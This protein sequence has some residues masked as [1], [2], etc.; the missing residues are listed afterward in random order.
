MIPLSKVGDRKSSTL[1]EPALLEV[2]TRFVT[3]KD[4]ALGRTTASKHDLVVV[5]VVG[6]SLAQRQKQNGI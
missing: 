6:P 1:A 4:E 5:E 3:H 2:I